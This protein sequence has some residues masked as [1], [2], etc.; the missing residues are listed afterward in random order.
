MQALRAQLA[1]STQSVE[2]LKKI[3]QERL[4]DSMGLGSAKEMQ[5]EVVV[6]G[7]GKGVEG[8]ERDDDSHYFEVSSLGPVG[9]V[10]S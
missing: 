1:D 10:R 7:K 8:E 5:E 3:I 9:K 2:Q 4:G 6:K